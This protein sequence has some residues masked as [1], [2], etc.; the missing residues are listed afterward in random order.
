MHANGSGAN[1]K[2]TSGVQV[3]YGARPSSFL[4]RSSSRRSRKSK[5]FYF[6]SN[7]SGQAV[8]VSYAH[9]LRYGISEVNSLD[10]PIGQ[11]F[12]A[13]REA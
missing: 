1:A 10:Q 3:A 2:V 7:N 8:P 11:S 12:I 4:E 6:G 13:S 5:S 9:G